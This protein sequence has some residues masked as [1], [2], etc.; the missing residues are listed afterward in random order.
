MAIHHAKR[1][2]SVLGWQATSINLPHWQAD[3]LGESY[4]GFI[5]IISLQFT[6]ILI[7]E[8]TAVR[9]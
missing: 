7:V 4:G 9:L 2:D 3:L 1:K 5:W 6:I 8:L